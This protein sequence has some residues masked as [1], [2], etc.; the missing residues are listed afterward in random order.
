MY[1]RAQLHEQYKQRA[2]DEIFKKEFETA[3]EKELIARRDKANYIF[4]QE[5]IEKSMR[6]KDHS[7]PQPLV[8]EGDDQHQTKKWDSLIKTAAYYVDRPNLNQERYQ[9]RLMK[10]RYDEL[11]TD[12]WRP[13]LQSRRDLVTW[14]CEQRNSALAETHEPLNCAYNSLMMDF[15][16]DTEGLKQKL[17]DIKGLWS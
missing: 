16:P 1:D 13:P 5:D 17:G 6:L 8:I 3:V 4:A 15:G 10:Q 9:L 7:A 14:A 11:F 12:S 2:K